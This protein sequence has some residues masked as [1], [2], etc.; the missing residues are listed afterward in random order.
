MMTSLLSV[1][2]FNQADP[3]FLTLLPH[4][5]LVEALMSGKMAKGQAAGKTKQK[6]QPASSSTNPLSSPWMM[7]QVV[8]QR[9]LCFTTINAWQCYS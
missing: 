8:A 7:E 4:P 1:K 6:N 9:A 3:L 2:P 5:Y